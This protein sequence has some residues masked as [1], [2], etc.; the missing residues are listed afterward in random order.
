MS[1]PVVENVDQTCGT[2]PNQLEGFINKHPFYFRARHGAW[3]LRVAEI[4]Q[5]PVEGPVVAFGD[6]PHAGWWSTDEARAAL[7]A[8]IQQAHILGV[9]PK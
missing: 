7:D 6:H 5:D 1:T 3:C 2:C 9:L 8:A 4:G